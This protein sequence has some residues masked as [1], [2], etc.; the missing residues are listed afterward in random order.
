MLLISLQLLAAFLIKRFL[1]AYVSISIKHCC[2][3]HL[4]LQQ[5][6]SNFI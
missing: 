3:T 5:E 2:V 6:I 4:Y 1:G